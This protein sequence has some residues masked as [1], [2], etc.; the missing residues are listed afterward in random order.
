VHAWR[1][2]AEKRERSRK[3]RRDSTT[4]ERLAWR[5]LRDR[6][7]LGLKFRRQHP[8]GRFIVDF[9]CA[10]L[11]VAIELDGGYHDTPEQHTRDAARTAVL[12]ARGIRVV[13]I[14]NSHVTSANFRALI[15]PYVPP[16]RECGEG[17]RG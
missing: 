7:L 13:R 12:E 5:L 2:K 3:L 14:R 10:E 9:Y 6:R 4:A 11:H 17:A 8:I 15:Q 16:L 1:R